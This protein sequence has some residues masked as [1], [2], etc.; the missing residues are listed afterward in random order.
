MQEQE[1]VQ[2]E[3]FHGLGLDLHLFP[4]LEQE[5][6]EE[7]EQGTDV[8]LVASGPPAADSRR[9]ANSPQGPTPGASVRP[10]PGAFWFDGLDGVSRA[11]AASA[12][13]SWPR[14]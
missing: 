2:H 14:E 12:F 11:N 3:L 7:L 1:E 5:V 6:Q 4:L 13:T 9:A 10:W 8:L